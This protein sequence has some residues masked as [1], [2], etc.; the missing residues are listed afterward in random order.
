M[1]ASLIGLRIISMIRVLRYPLT[2]MQETGMTRRT[3]EQKIAHLDEQKRLL[4][5]RLGKQERTRDTRR[6]ILLGALVL[7]RVTTST[8]ETDVA[9]LKSWMSR[10]LPDFLTRDAD[11]LLLADLFA[12]AQVPDQSTDNG[13][14]KISVPGRLLVPA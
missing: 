7:Q 11:R 6:K 10:E 5:A 13:N 3:I 12:P 8:N 14:S 4:Q 9:W 1:L 2:P